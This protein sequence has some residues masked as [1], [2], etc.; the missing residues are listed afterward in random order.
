MKNYEIRHTAN[1][2]GSNPKFNI[3]YLVAR[4]IVSGKSMNNE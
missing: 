3:A 2:T 4:L 1:K